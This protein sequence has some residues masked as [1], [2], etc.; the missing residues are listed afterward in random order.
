MIFKAIRPQ[1]AHS[2]A[3]QGNPKISDEIW[4]YVD[5]LKDNPFAVSF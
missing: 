2:F 4:G 5:N 3:I 1:Q